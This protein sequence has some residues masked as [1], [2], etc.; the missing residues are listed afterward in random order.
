MPHPRL[1]HAVGALE[2]RGVVA[3][4]SLHDRLLQNR[5]SRRRFAQGHRRS[6]TCSGALVERLDGDG[7]AVLPFADLFSP[8]AWT[9][10]QSQGDAFMSQTEAGLAAD[11]TDEGNAL[12]RREGK[13]FVVRAH[14]WEGAS[15]G[16]DDAVVQRLHL[17]PAA[18]SS[19]TGTCACG[20][21]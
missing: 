6:T 17:G 16:A 21:S 12:K 2:R 13:E 10:L 4:Y 8:A 7:Y 14:S 9:A 1:R 20:P 19:R 5:S 15:L 11:G 3:T 18:R